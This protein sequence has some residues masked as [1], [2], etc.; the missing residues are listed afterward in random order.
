MS[1]INL[2]ITYEFLTG[3]KMN[4]NREWFNTNKSKYIEAKEEF[5]KFVG[6]LISEIKEIDNSIGEQ[7]A[8]NC[9]FRIYKDVR[10]SKNKE[11]YKT[12]FGA[13]IA[14]GGRKS[15]YAGYYFHFEPGGS[16]M[17]G[18]IYMPQPDILR[19]IRNAIYNDS[20]HLK[21]II[22][23]RNF[24]NTFG[25]IHGEKLKSYPRGFNKYFEDIELIKYKHYTVIKEVDDDFWFNQ[26]MIK[27]ILKIV[28]AQYNFNKYL[29]SIIDKQISYTASKKLSAKEEEEFI[30]NNFSM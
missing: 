27:N 28:E 12:N 30:K 5:E 23:N 3:L 6:A 16:F 4:N 9:V 17:G 14:K 26:D 20:S 29:N 1:F 8:K 13:V 15:P 7:E 10:F 22:N 21:K 2:R 18:G 25:E 19:A 11:P 24:K